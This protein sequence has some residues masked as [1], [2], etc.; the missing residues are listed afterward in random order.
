MIAKAK[1]IANKWNIIAFWQG[2]FKMALET[3]LKLAIR[4][5]DIEQVTHLSLLKKYLSEGPIIKRLVSTY[6]DTPDFAIR[7]HQMGLRIREVE[8]HFIQTLK[9]GGSIQEG[10]HQR[11]ELECEVDNLSPRLDL[12]SDPAVRKLLIEQIQLPLNPVFCTDFT[13]TTWFLIL[14]DTTHIEFDLDVGEARTSNQR[15]SFQEIELELLSGNQE[16]LHQI[17]SEIAEFISIFPEHR[18]KASR[19][20][21]LLK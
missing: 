7:S 11:E 14:P 10:L 9:Y 21:A 3:E 20:Y 19:G 8:G 17:A 12:I 2:N 15:Q 6:F 5:E 16:A 4:P 1:Y 13:R 18:S